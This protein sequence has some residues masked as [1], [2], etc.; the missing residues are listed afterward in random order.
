MPHPL[1]VLYPLKTKSVRPKNVMAANE[2]RMYLQYR[3]SFP[4]VH[5]RSVRQCPGRSGLSCPSFTQLPKGAVTVTHPY[6][7]FSS[8][9]SPR[10]S[11]HS[12][13]RHG[14]GEKFS[15]IDMETV[16]IADLARDSSDCTYEPKRIIAVTYVGLRPVEKCTRTDYRRLR[17]EDTTHK[18]IK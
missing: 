2:L 8:R 6:V 11:T 13:P 7:R 16:R 1:T 5:G 4:T 17:I 15:F 9:V 3:K 10:R 12:R 14:E 18:K